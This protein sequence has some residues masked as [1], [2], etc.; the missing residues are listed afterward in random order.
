MQISNGAGGPVS[1]AGVDSRNR[2]LTYTTNR[3][4][5]LSYTY[6]GQAFSQFINV[7]PANGATIFFVLG[8][9]TATTPIVVDL[10]NLF[11]ANNDN[12]DI[13]VGP[14]NSPTVSGQT[15]DPLVNKN[16]STARACPWVASVGTS[17]TTS[18]TL[19]SVDSI[20]LYSAS[21]YVPSSGIL[22]QPGYCLALRTTTGNHAIRGS[23]H[24]YVLNGVQTGSWVE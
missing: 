21:S 12:V 8:S 15:T 11:C 17:I 24:F 14:Y 20:P 22:L 18:S 5:S 2:L 10:F 9:S 3:S 4:E 13:L 23:V 6:D 16:V 1:L 19:T 7:T